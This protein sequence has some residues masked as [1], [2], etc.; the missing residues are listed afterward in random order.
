MGVYH[1]QWFGM[2]QVPVH[3]FLASPKS[4]RVSRRSQAWS[5]GQN[6]RRGSG[7][8]SANCGGRPRLRPSTPG[9]QSSCHQIGTAGL[10]RL[11]E[12]RKMSVFLTMQTSYNRVGLDGTELQ[13]IQKHASHGMVLILCTA[14]VHSRI[15]KNLILKTLHRMLAKHRWDCNDKRTCV[16]ILQ[17]VPSLHDPLLHF[18]A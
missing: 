2:E 6:M 18:T 1:N 15:L 14:I 9:L 16:A 10:D 11:P 17:R 8:E 13:S 3:N 4:Q 7:K 5:D 12:W